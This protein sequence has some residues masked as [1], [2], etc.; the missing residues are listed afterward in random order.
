MLTR[1][2]EVVG[3]APPANL[4]P[5]VMS[6][7][8]VLSYG[9]IGYLYRWMRNGGVVAIAI[10]AFLAGKNVYHV[11]FDGRAEASVLRI[12]IVCFL[13][14]ESLIYRAMTIET[15]CGDPDVGRAKAPPDVAL[16]LQEETYVR[17]EFKSEIGAEYRVRARAARL[18]ITGPERGMTLPILYNRAN[19]KEVWPLPTVASYWKAASAFAGGIVTLLIALFARRAA[20]YRGDVEAEVAALAKAAGREAGVAPKR[21]RAA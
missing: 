11:T 18:G 10:S 20:N 9:L 16:E 6:K 2:W 4:G 5:F 17:L 14:G 12:E 7:N 13:R 1:L 21:R 15:E 8:A 3:Y 19:P